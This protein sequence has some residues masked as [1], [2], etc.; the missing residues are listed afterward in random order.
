[1]A[2]PGCGIIFAPSSQ[3]M[4]RS[5]S[6]RRTHSLNS[7]FKHSAS[8]KPPVTNIQERDY[9]FTHGRSRTISDKMIRSLHRKK[10]SNESDTSTKSNQ[11]TISA[12]A[13]VVSRYPKHLDLMDAA[14]QKER[15]CR[16]V[17]DLSRHHTG[18]HW[19]VGTGM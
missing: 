4:D 19:E 5:T 15:H 11:S 18:G 2:A 16:Q 10:N 14:S 3:R 13:P 7:K 17:Q 8:N 1:M 6:L 9:G 12:H